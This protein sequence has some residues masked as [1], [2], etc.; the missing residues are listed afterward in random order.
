[1]TVLR[2]I[3]TA[4]LLII[5]AAAAAG[6]DTTTQADEVIERGP[7]KPD[8]S[9]CAGVGPASPYPDYN[10]RPLHPDSTGMS[11]AAMELAHKIR[12]G[13]NLGNTLEAI[14]GETAW[15]NPRATRGLIR[16]VKSSGFD[17]IRIPASWD[18]YADPQTA[19]IDEKSLNRVKEVI[20]YALDADLAVVL[21]IHWDG[22]WLENNVTAEKKEE[23]NTRQRAYWQQIA[24]HLRNFDERLMFAGANEPNVDSA[25]QMS[26][27]NS[28]H[29]TFVD[30]VRCTGGKNAYRILV[31]QGPGTDIEKTD[32]FWTGMPS[33]VIP[34]RLMAEVHFY[35]PYNFAL[36]A[37]DEDWGKQ[38]FYWGK[39]NHSDTDTAHNPT[40]GEED[41]LDELFA[42]MKYKFV[43]RGIPVIIGEYGAIR[44]NG[45][46]GEALERHLESRAYYLEYV[47]RQSLANGLLPF[48]WDNGVMGDSGFGIFDRGKET[49]FDRQA[50]DAL[51]KGA[52]K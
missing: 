42:K 50:L 33:D 46:S 48:Y 21:N 49:V 41:A 47:T 27:L 52:G 25:E 4:A 8:M 23:N 5:P 17:A 7:D 35:T 28:Y 10:A 37:K 18:Q 3:L 34:G 45:L 36:M 12:L 22:G 2:K 11:L 30:A 31:V 40:W 9:R 1:M 19:K 26:V 16:R 15:G 51:L 44:R 20:R 29:Q 6:S 38:F 32:R 24:T 13:W 39:G 43:D 14:G